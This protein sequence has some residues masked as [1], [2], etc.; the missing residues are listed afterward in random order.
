MRSIKNLLF[1]ITFSMIGFG[2]IAQQPFPKKM[3]KEM[4][5]KVVDACRHA[6]EGY[7]KYAWGFDDLRPLTKNGRNWYKQSMLMSPVDAFD[8]FIMLGMKK[9]AA[10]A[11]ELILSKLSFDVD[12]DVQV[13]EIV[14]RL[15]AALQTAYEMDGDKR[16]LTLA[17]D[18]AKRLMPAF[19]TPTGIPY[20]YVHLQTG[21]TRDHLNNPA[22]IG[23]LM[24]EFGKLS[25][26]TGNATYYNTAK[27]AI[28]LVYEK[29]SAIG[30]VGEVIDANTG[31]WTRTRSHISGYI[32]SYYEYLYKSWKLFGDNDFKT[33]WDVHE[34]AIK[35]Y[36]IRKQP[37]GWFM[38]QVDMNTGQELSTVYG[39][40]DAFYAGLTAYA[41]DVPTAREMQKANYYMW[42]RFNI[43]PE[44]FDFKKDSILYASYV[45]RPENIESCF[46]LYRLTGNDTYLHM[47]K[48]MV[49][50]IITHCKAEAGFASLKSVVTKEKSNGMESFLF[51]ETFKYAY[52][53]FAP[54]SAID[55]DKVVLTTEAHPFKI[56]KK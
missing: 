8:T 2:S 26:L 9:E 7:K 23:T 17:E 30:L 49:D 11:K 5:A 42:T 54:R 48:R 25:K 47:G 51:G 34:A 36:L 45:L 12:N 37:N 46:Y 14:I 33:A 3:K 15:L 52:L 31:Q 27:K 6:W 13:F 39:A 56:E 55:L 21:K 20:R 24:M 44:E 50:D 4:A 38:A 28:M 22:E 19:N 35:K 18:L 43:E 53:L 16:F 29:R 41:G 10:E 32:D 1:T 40:L